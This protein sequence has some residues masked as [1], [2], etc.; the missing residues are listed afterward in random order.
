MRSHIKVNRKKA[1]PFPGKALPLL[2]PV[3]LKTLES[4][5]T[6]TWGSVNLEKLKNDPN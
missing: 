5:K 4:S 6:R 3:W 2:F 1:Q